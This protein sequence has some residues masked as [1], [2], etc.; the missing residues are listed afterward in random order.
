MGSKR[1][2]VKLS[3]Q[4]KPDQVEDAIQE[5]ALYFL[6]RLETYSHVTPSLFVQVAAM[7]AKNLVRDN[8]GD[9]IVSMG[10]LN[11]LAGLESPEPPEGG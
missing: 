3:R 11:D 1:A 8:H 7:R 6:D 2:R 10:S 9:L 5:A 4:F